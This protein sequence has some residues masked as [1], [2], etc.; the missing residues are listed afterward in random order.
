MDFLERHRRRP[1]KSDE[2]TPLHPYCS[3]YAWLLA[4]FLSLHYCSLKFAF[5]LALSVPPYS[6]TAKGRN[7]GD[8]SGI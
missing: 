6:P 8:V 3:A 1:V 4:L 5:D 7:L 2:Y